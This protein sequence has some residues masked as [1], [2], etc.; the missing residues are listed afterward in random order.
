M[1]NKLPRKRKKAFIK[2]HGRGTY[3]AFQ[4]VNEIVLEERGYSDFKFPKYKYI[5]SENQ[6][7]GFW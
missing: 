4:M 7:I 3:I 1:K 6:F 2:E 5:N